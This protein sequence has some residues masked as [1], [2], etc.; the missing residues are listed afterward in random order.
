[1]V[2]SQ[3]QHL[4]QSL[5]RSYSGSQAVIAKEI[6]ATDGAAARR[7]VSSAF[8]LVEIAKAFPARTV[9]MMQ[10]PGKTQTLTSESFYMII[11]YMELT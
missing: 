10:S 8:Q 5:L 3:L 11:P 7:T 9:V 4:T 6:A 2:M 1:M